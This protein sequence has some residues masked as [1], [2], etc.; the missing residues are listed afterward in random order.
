MAGVAVSAWLLWGAFRLLHISADA[1]MD[2]ELDEA[3]RAAILEL[4]LRD[5][6][7]LGVQDLRTRASGPII[8]VQAHVALDP[9][10]T[11]EAAHHVLVEAENR[12][13]A[14]FPAADIM[15]QPDPAGRAEPHAG[16]FAKAVREGP[17]A[18]PD[19]S[20]SADAA[21]DENG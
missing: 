16:V 2:R 11:I 21:M 5:P 19:A 10:H 4:I 12:I 15:L 20:R 18:H 14:R 6:Q 9:H 7:V 3:E 8:H 13:L 17:A 1:L